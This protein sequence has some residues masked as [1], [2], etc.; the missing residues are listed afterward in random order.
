MPHDFAENPSNDARELAHARPFARQGSRDMEISERNGSATIQGQTA[1][2]NTSSAASCDPRRSALDVARGIVL[3]VAFGTTTSSW[4]RAVDA[5][6]ASQGRHIIGEQTTHA[7]WN[8][9]HLLDWGFP[10]F[11]IM[12]AASMTLSRERHRARGQST[13]RFV[14]R[15]VTRGILLWVFAF[16]F[17]G[18][19]SVPLTEIRFSRVFFLLSACI[20][21]TG[22]SLA[23]LKLRGQLLAFFLFLF[24]NWAFMALFPV[25]GYASG[26]FSAAGNALSYVEDRLVDATGGAVWQSAGLR[27]LH[28]DLVLLFGLAVM[29]YGTCLVG[30]LEGQILV[31][32]QSLQAQVLTLAIGGIIATTLALVWDIWFPINKHLWNGSFTLLTG[33]LSFVV[34]AG[35]I[36][37]IEVWG[38]QRLGY[39]FQVFGR[40]SLAAWTCYFLLPWDNFA[41]RLFGPSFPPVFGVYRPLVINIT[42]VALCWLLF[43]WFDNRRTKMQLLI[44]RGAQ[45]DEWPKRHPSE[46]T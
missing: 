39:P 42:Q 24:A 35:I 45:R 37:V 2:G 41:Q 32:K 23:L 28:R 3:F 20:V 5:L 30:L 8:G 19:F 26:D 17:Y 13:W 29:S 18:G 21:L 12:L 9:F 27:H 16:F 6:P 46:A 4:D 40:Y 22:L 33:G 34:F 31:S 11:M 1:S 10:A 43:V 44:Q 38:F 14:A 7:E 36:Q 25:P 15:V